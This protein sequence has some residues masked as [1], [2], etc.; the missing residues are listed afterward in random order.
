MVLCFF[1]LILATKVGAETGSAFNNYLLFDLFFPQTETTFE[2]Q[3]SAVFNATVGK[4]EKGNIEDNTMSLSLSPNIP[5]DTDGQQSVRLL[6]QGKWH[7]IKREIE[8]DFRSHSIGVSYLQ[9]FSQETKFGLGPLLYYLDAKD[10][11]KSSL[12]ADLAG[13]MLAKWNELQLSAKGSFYTRIDDDILASVGDSTTRRLLLKLG[14]ENEVWEDHLLGFS[15]EGESGKLGTVALW[16]LVPGVMYK[17]DDQQNLWYLGLQYY[18]CFTEKNIADLNQILPLHDQQ[19]ENGTFL[20]ASLGTILNL[21]K[22]FILA[23]EMNL[24]YFDEINFLGSVSLS[25][26]FD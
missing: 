18:L 5:I 23:P 4:I 21:G 22:N 26:P 14:V 7:S 16:R 15:L 8:T 1:I 12:G 9:Q 6:W 24:Y 25:V 2:S 20:K 13:F 11:E 10:I 19:E 17:Y 3:N